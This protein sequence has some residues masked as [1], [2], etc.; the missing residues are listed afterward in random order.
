MSVVH[1][2]NDQYKVFD[3][4]RDDLPNLDR[5][6]ET[7]ISIPMHNQLPDEDVEHVIACIQ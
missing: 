5:L 4:L 6:S 7:Y 1:V 3:G 2:R